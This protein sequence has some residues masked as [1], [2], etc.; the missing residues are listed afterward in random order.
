[1]NSFSN[2]WCSS[3]SANFIATDCPVTKSIAEYHK[4]G[5]QLNSK[6][7]GVC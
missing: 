4:N 1:M 2:E 6:L 5:K 7:I 3:F